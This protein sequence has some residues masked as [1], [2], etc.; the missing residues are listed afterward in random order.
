MIRD[1]ECSMYQQ[2][3]GQD[4]ASLCEQL[5][6]CVCGD[7]EDSF[8]FHQNL[9]ALLK[10]HLKAK[11][12]P[13]PPGESQKKK[14]EMDKPPGRLK[15]EAGFLVLRLQAST[16]QGTDGPSSSHDRQSW[17]EAV[18][19][20]GQAISGNGKECYFHIGYMNF[21]SWHFAG[22]ELVSEGVLDDGSFSLRAPSIPVFR[23]SLT[24][25][26]ECIDLEHA[27]MCSLLVLHSTDEPVP[28]SQMSAGALRAGVF[29]E[30][31][32]FWV[33]KGRRQE[34][35]QRLQFQRARSSNNKKRSNAPRRPEAAVPDAI[36]DV[37]EDEDLPI[38]A[39]VLQRLGGVDG[40]EEEP[41]DS[42]GGENAQEADDAANEQGRPAKRARPPRAPRPRQAAA[43]A[44][45]A[46]A[47]PGPAAPRPAVPVPPV[48]AP[49]VPAPDM[50]APAVAEPLQPRRAVVGRS[51]T[52]TE[53]RFSTP[54]GDL[55]FYPQNS[56]MSAF[57][58]NP[59]HNDCRRN[60]TVKPSE[61]IFRQGQGRPI[62]LLMA[63]LQQSND[64]A[65]K[66]EHVRWC[67]PGFRHRQ[68]G[69]SQFMALN[70]AARFAAHERPRRPDE[71]NDE[72]HEIV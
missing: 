8:H 56:T 52:G 34:R 44:A 37:Y 7:G 11:A 46:P 67:N 40:D 26:H 45:P 38:A 58:T 18:R 13:R 35:L 51:R 14:K 1:E 62:G 64:Y 71:D 68:S 32:S 60:R 17:S 12:K 53:V 41:S 36:A 15:I 57:C 30:I 59:R 54:V 27:W 31:P 25:V 50:P 48:P 10:P 24:F 55:A 70:D 66:D 19:L 42:D 63:W 2:G 28:W 39:L 72:P 69:R 16:S 23:R 6:F 20:R 9:T 22:I 4:R 3:T 5:M 49:A 61:N 47:A 21:A 33:W 43:P 65:T 29:Q